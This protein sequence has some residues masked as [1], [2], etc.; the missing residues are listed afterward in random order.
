M[1]GAEEARLGP[2]GLAPQAISSVF[3]LGW[4]A[5]HSWLFRAANLLAIPG[6]EQG[7]RG[8]Q[9]GIPAAAP[10]CWLC[11]QAAACCACQARSNSTGQR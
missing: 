6:A 10:R 8:R 9:P 11:A 7:P 5:G 3:C 4:A 1:G 2:G